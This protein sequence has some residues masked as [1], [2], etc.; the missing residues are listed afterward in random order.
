MNIYIPLVKYVPM[1]L[2]LYQIRLTSFSVPIGI[3]NRGKA[4]KNKH[5]FEG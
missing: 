4:E 3:H 1:C 2:K 5:Y